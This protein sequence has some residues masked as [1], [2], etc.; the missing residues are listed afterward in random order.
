MTKNKGIHN[1]RSNQYH[2]HANYRYSQQYVQSMHHSEGMINIPIVPRPYP[3]HIRCSLHNKYFW[4]A[5]TTSNAHAFK[6]NHFPISKYLRSLPSFSH[7]TKQVWI[8]PDL[9][10]H[11]NVQHAHGILKKGLPSLLSFCLVV[12]GHILRYRMMI[13]EKMLWVERRI[14]RAANL[15]CG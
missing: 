11:G 5:P 12:V 10:K 15:S 14:I 2:I 6:F 8:H 13:S 4:S 1:H 3:C 7:F 9:I